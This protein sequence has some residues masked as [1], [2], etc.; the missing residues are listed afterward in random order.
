LQEEIYKSHYLLGRIFTFQ[1]NLSKAA[2][3]YA[4]AIA[5]IERILNDL[6]YD[7]SPS[8]LQTAWVV[9]EDMIALCLQQSQVERAFNYLERARSMA[10]L[11]YLS[12]SRT[13]QSRLEE[14]QD[15]VSPPASQL[16]SAAVLRTQYELREWQERYHDYNILLSDIDPSVS[17]TVDREVIQTELKRCEAKL[18][19]LFERL[20]LYQSEIPVVSPTPRS[21]K[22]VHSKQV[23]VETVQLRQ[24]LAADQLL[25]AYFLS[26]GKLVIFAVTPERL[27]I[28]ENP[29]GVEQLEYLLPILHA[30]LQ[31]GGWPDPQQPP[32]HPIRRLLNKLYDLLVAPV[33]SL[34]PFSSGL[35]TIVPY[36]P[37]HKLPFHALHNGSHFLIEDFEVNYLPASNLLIHLSTRDRTQDISCPN[38]EK[39]TRP[40]LVLGYSENG[41]LPRI[42]DEARTIASLLNGHCFL[43][44]EATIANLIQ[45]APG[46]PIIHLATHGQSRLDAPN[47]SYIRLAD[48]QLNAFDAFSLNLDEC[49]LVTL[50]GC[51]TGLALSGGGDEQLGLGRAFLAA[52]ATSLVMSLW[53]VE[54][55][56]T[57]E[58]MKLFYQHLLKGESKVQAL[59]AAQCRLLQRSESIYTH[60]YFWAAFRLVGDVGPIKYQSIKDWSLALAIEPLK[61]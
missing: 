24:H 9:Y 53:S 18:S 47:F 21:K 36:G 6:V 31:P 51:E 35:L 48:G 38:T 58:L 3:H 55:N 56:V 2:R 5:Q 7:L 39:S 11:Q 28:H 15:F 17:P 8:F 37:L 33:T 45:Q 16:N 43:E 10:L 50:S 52:G 19:E 14:P 54:D 22:R 12:K 26:K 29:N 23:I 30:H 25:L 13:S 4:A 1:E 49:E 60:P 32:Q 57:N 20:Y 27:I 61:K 46:S 34:L 59:R 41:H 44:R 42:N 40:P